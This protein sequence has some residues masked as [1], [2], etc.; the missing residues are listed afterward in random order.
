MPSHSP[1][2][3]ALV[4][5]SRRHIEG[6]REQLL[7]AV[8]A[9]PDLAP[10]LTHADLEAAV[11]RLLDEQPAARRRDRKEATVLA[12]RKLADSLAE[13]ARWDGA[14]VH[15]D[16]HGLRTLVASGA[17]RDLRFSGADAPPRAMSLAML[18]KVFGE[19]RTCTVTELYL[20]PGH[21]VLAY[22]ALGARGRFRLALTHLQ[23]Q[24]Q[25]GAIQAWMDQ[26]SCDEYVNVRLPDFA[27]ADRKRTEAAT[28]AAAAL[29]AAKLPAAVP[30][31]AAA[32][33]PP[34]PH[35]PVAAAPRPRPVA[36][37]PLPTPRPRPVAARP[38]P[39]R[40]RL[41][42]GILLM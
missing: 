4:R 27:E 33:V 12:V 18:R 13:T 11:L 37:P 5:M 32:P 38:R 7:E 23:P 22:S 19:C 9:D 39:A 14:H 30:V 41:R 26:P 34:A 16:P 28:L 8:A 29:A 20:E 10:A 36:A 42:E 17:S 40:P 15:L 25:P 24:G 2:L 1:P 6:A 31:P 35:Q 21:L 3:R